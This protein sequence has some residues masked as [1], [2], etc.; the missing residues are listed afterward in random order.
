MEIPPGAAGQGHDE[1]LG[2]LLGRD[3]AGH[4]PE[5]VGVGI[6]ES[7]GQPAVERP[8]GRAGLGVPDRHRRG[9]PPRG[10]LL[11]A[12]VA[13]RVEQIV[14]VVGED[15]GV[16]QPARGKH[17]VDP[18]HRARVGARRERLRVRIGGVDGAA[19]DSGHLGVLLRRAL[20]E[21]VVVGFVPDLPIADVVLVVFDDGAD[22]SGELV[23]VS[24]RLAMDAV[25]GDVGARRTGP[26]RHPKKLAQEL[27]AVLARQTHLVVEPDEAA[28]LGL[29]G[30]PVG[31]VLAI[32]DPRPLHSHRVRH[33]Q[34][35][36]V[37]SEMAADDRR[38]RRNGAHGRQ[39][40]QRQLAQDVRRRRAT[41][42]EKRPCRKSAALPPP[43]RP[44]SRPESVPPAPRRPLAGRGRSRGR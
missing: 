33:A 4:R 42:R 11:D 23:E 14:A 17:V 21:P 31:E 7:V 13:L 43:P 32:V 1:Q 36:L 2:A 44:V 28:L 3:V 26:S 19:G 29:G 35:E 22:V 5:P 20:P 16:G 8:R 38:L 12:A 6:G 15:V 41:R 40:A 39:H 27:H 24:R 10:P 37:E 30:V 25:A 9:P 34:V 18:L